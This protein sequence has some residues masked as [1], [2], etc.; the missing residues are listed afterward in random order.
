[1][2]ITVTITQEKTIDT[3]DLISY[4]K[5]VMEDKDSDSVYVT[6]ESLVECI[7]VIECLE[8]KNNNLT[9]KLAK[10]AAENLRENMRKIPGVNLEETAKA[11]KLAEETE[12]LKETSRFLEEIIQEEFDELYEFWHKRL[13]DVL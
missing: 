12:K 10:V 6:K 13:G 5:E 11:L 4:F 8:K 2:K 1:M 3:T 9:A 7:A